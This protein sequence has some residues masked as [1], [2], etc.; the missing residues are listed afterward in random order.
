[1]N[2]EISFNRT[3]KL[4][5]A[6]GDWTKIKAVVAAAK[7]VRPGLFS[8]DRLGESELTR[9]HL[10]HY[11]FGEE[12]IQK[13]TKDL[14]IKLVLRSVS[15]EQYNYRS[16]RSKL[17][18]GLVQAEVVLPAN[19]RFAI[20][21]DLPL[22][23]LLLNRAM[24]GATEDFE[25]RETLSE[26]DKKALQTVITQYFSSLQHAWGSAETQFLFELHHPDLI[27]D[28]AISAGDG[29]VAVTVELGIGDDLVQKMI[30]LYSNKVLRQLIKQLGRAPF[31]ENINLQVKTK[32]TILIP[33]RAELGE[34]ELVMEELSALEAGDVI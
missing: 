10:L 4:P 16:F 27:G 22:L 6:I 32:K 15:S 30:F 8:F 29:V 26:L 7:Q 12:L 11:R 34:T 21:Y 13:L 18:G 24:G 31:V 9:I 17:K 5:A 23:E 33:I 20:Y 19:Q 28:T 25:H 2:E 14:K 1:M 3:L